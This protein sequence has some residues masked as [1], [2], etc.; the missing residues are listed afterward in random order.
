MNQLRPQ[1]LVIERT[2]YL[3]LQSHGKVVFLGFFFLLTPQNAL[4]RWLVGTFY[5]LDDLKPILIIEL[6][7]L[8]F[9]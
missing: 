9:S 3:P 4:S 7:F 2:P 5:Q 8:T 1:D 6:N